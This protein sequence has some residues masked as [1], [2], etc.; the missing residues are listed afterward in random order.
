M[1][2]TP[3]FSSLL[4]AA[5]LLAASNGLA[6]NATRPNIIIMLADDLGWADVGY[7]GSDI[8]T[9]SLDRLAN[10]GM[11]L[12]RFYVNPICT[13]TRAALLTGRDALRMGVGY[14]PILAWS[15]KAVSPQEHFMP[16]TFKAA[17]YQTGMVG[18][19]H[20]GHTLEPH[21]PNAR[22]F[23]DF[24]G[25]LHTQVFY[26][27][28]TTSGG[29]D[30]QHNGSSV[31]RDGK[32][33][34]D[35]HG[36][37]AARFIKNRDSSKPFFLYVPF[38]APHSPME[39]P[40]EL[41][42]KYAD[43]PVVELPESNPLRQM[44]S[45][46]DLR[47]VQQVYAAMVDSMD[48]AIGKIL[49]TL[50]EEGI[51]DDTI[52]LF[53]S[54]NGGFNGFGASNAPLRGEKM[55][56][57]EGGIRVP[58]LIRWPGQIQSGAENHQMISVMDVFPTLAT[59]AGIPTKNSKPLDGQSAWPLAPGSSFEARDGDVFF[60]AEQP[61]A[62]PYFYAVIRDQWKLVQVL[63]EDLYSKRVENLLYDIAADP[64][65][66]NNLASKEPQRVAELASRIAAWA[67]LHPVAGQHVE[68]A[69]NP[70]WLP[71]KDWADVVIPAEKIL[72]N[73]VDGFTKGTADR[74]Q[75]AYEG[76]GRVIY[77]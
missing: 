51:A 12:E 47:Q 45:P 37:E 4:M 76:R 28:H 1:F 66:T 31:R 77:D 73:S 22:G 9:P 62:S 67:A 41:I 33:L 50:D 57:F 6:D 35:V 49:A 32:Y 23:D 74:L 59:A 44:V 63:H 36:E 75:K 3:K 19:W 42:K 71:P 46:E 39:A 27:A 64:E 25:H 30:L 40:V 7:H 43:R 18:K 60:V 14:F 69:P 2:K 5:I 52:V 11:R 20:L 13:P 17:G 16:E 72:P 55:T 61:T 68:I 21:T 58:A 10:E 15:N 53:L 29:H 65:E 54:D 24:F 38:L 26:Y 48:Q 8:A 70:G 56:V 34:T